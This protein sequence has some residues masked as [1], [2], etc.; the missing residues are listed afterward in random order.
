MKTVNLWTPFLY[1]ADSPAPCAANHA[2]ARC[3]EPT[4][5]RLQTAFT[6]AGIDYNIDVP[7]CGKHGGEFRSSTEK[8]AQ[9]LNDYAVT[10]ATTK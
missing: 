5:V 3:K 6:A 4:Y 10:H 9:E 2:T 1:V 8:T 7:I